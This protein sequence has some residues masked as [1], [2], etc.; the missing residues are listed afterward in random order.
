MKF[1]EVAQTSHL[2]SNRVVEYFDT[3]GRTDT[4]VQKI[5]VPV[6]PKDTVEKQ[7]TGLDQ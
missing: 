2:L 6:F 4:G 1:H 3:C 5:G 7:R